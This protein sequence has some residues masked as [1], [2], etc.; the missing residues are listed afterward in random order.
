MTHTLPKNLLTMAQT[1]GPEQKDLAM[2]IMK[3]GIEDDFSLLSQDQG[4]IDFLGEELALPEMPENHVLMI[5]D[6]LAHPGLQLRHARQIIVRGFPVENLLPLVYHQEESIRDAAGTAIARLLPTKGLLFLVKNKAGLVDGAAGVLLL[7]TVTNRGFAVG[8]LD[9][10]IRENE[11]YHHFLVS[12]DPFLQL[13][14][15]AL[16]SDERPVSGKYADGVAAMGVYGVEEYDLSAAS[17]SA[18]WVG[19][20][21]QYDGGSKNLGRRELLHTRLISLLKS[22]NSK[23]L[24][25]VCIALYNLTMYPANQKIWFGN[26]VLIQAL[27]DAVHRADPATQGVIAELLDFYAKKQI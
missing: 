5:A 23:L 22:N 21:A 14:E 18:L 27:N 13:I 15:H 25:N 20:I 19:E 8:I 6:T 24:S 10:F 1:D 16:L 26:T 11:D 3:K 12:H 17:L 9:K 2:W 7:D 4:W